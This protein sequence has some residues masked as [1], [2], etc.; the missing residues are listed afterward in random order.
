MVAKI[1]FTSG[2]FSDD[3]RKFE[4]TITEVLGFSERNEGLV[5]VEENDDSTDV[6]DYILIL[7]FPL[8][9]AAEAV[10]YMTMLSPEFH[11]DWS[12]LHEEYRGW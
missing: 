4:R 5:R 12:E 3:L 9:K 7:D 10:I 11:I 8:T 2:A 6:N 1:K